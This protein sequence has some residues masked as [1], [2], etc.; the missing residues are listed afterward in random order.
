MSKSDRLRQR[1]VTIGEATAFL[2][3]RGKSATPRRAPDNLTSLESE[4]ATYMSESAGRFSD[5]RSARLIANAA[6]GSVVAEWSKELVR[7]RLKEAARGGER[8]TGRVGPSS[9][10]GFWPEVALF[11]DITAADRNIIYQAELDGTRAPARPSG[12]GGDRDVS[13][14]EASI[15]WPALYLKAEEHDAAR[16]ALQC[17]GWCEARR[18]SFSGQY[19]ELGC[20]LRTANRRVDEAIETILAGLIRDGVDP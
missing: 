15:Y 7:Q 17:W 5:E 12:V 14:I 13:Q 16:R 1:L 4:A 10:L 9:K 2:G 11:A 3:N 18:Q 20:S 8:I 19:R 6:L